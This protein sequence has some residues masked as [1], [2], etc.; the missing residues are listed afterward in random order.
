LLV[1]VETRIG[2]CIAPSSVALGSG[3]QA[4][5]A[6]P[7]NDVSCLLTIYNKPISAVGKDSLLGLLLRKCLAEL[8]V[9]FEGAAA[10]LEAIPAT[11]LCI[12]RF[13]G[14]SSLF[15]TDVTNYCND[16]ADAWGLECEEPA[17]EKFSHSAQQWTSATVAAQLQEVSTW[18]KGVFP[19]VALQALERD[20]GTRSIICAVTCG[21]KPSVFTSTE[22]HRCGLTPADFRDPVLLRLAANCLSAAQRKSILTTGRLETENCVLK[23]S[24]WQSGRNP[25]ALRT[26]YLTAL[27]SRNYTAAIDVLHAYF[28][29]G[30]GTTVGGG[31]AFSGSD[32]PLGLVTSVYSPSLYSQWGRIRELLVSSVSA[33]AVGGTALGRSLLHYPLLHLGATELY[34][35][36]ASEAKNCFLESLRAAQINGDAAAVTLVSKLLATL[37]ESNKFP[38]PS[39]IQVWNT[40]H[41]H[42]LAANICTIM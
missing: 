14:I 11:I 42:I 24:K 17:C 34:F 20:A 5:S 32:T 8:T 16:F 23:E 30:Y 26:Q 21:V 13:E 4:A 15:F 41:H 27:E 19:P 28:D 1:L 29:Y 31:S 7:G 6:E 38:D 33:P 3:H 12:R 37:E 39:L 2:A 22:T 9:N 10:I 40:I 18:V 25:G 36:N 35:G